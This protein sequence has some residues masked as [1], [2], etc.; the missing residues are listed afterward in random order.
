MERVF[1]IS[2]IYPPCDKTG[3][4]R[5]LAI[6]KYFHLNGYYPVILTRNWDYP[7]KEDLDYM[8]STGDHIVEKNYDGHQEV[9]LPYEGNFRT[10][11][12]IKYLNRFKLL[13]KVLF[14]IDFLLMS[15]GIYRFSEYKIFYDYLFQY[16]KTHNDVK[17]IIIIGAPFHMFHI[18]FLLKKRFNV[19][20]IADYRDD[21]TTSEIQ[22]N[23]FMSV[24]HKIIYQFECKAEKK[25]VSTASYITSV[26]DVYTKRIADYVGV[27]GETVMNGYYEEQYQD[28][29]PEA[30][31]LFNEFTIFHN[32]TLYP[33]QKVEIF[34]E[35]YKLFIDDRIRGT[36]KCKLLFI[37][38]RYWEG[39]SEKIE[40]VLKGY[41]DYF[42]LT[43]RIPKQELIDIMM[44]S[45]VNLMISHGK[46][47]RGIASS[48]IFDY[49]MSRKP[50]IC[51]PSDGDIVE[52]LLTRSG[53]GVFCETPQEVYQELCK[54]SEK[55]MQ[56]EPYDSPFNEEEVV[57]FSR[58]VQTKR[59]AMLLD[60]M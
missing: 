37:G 36:N 42:E 27:A 6:S 18:G 4:D 52:E 17:K 25:W 38:I 29:K 11:F 28:S 60:K 26:S 20:W 50:V 24:F 55:Y 41:E 48:K 57:Q 19:E 35:G 53:Q 58:R 22:S 21:W 33:T 12:K 51:S 3:A 45:H 13:S 32:G 8:R 16:F 23:K 49:M 7:L 39:I 2:Y 54:L 47:I 14:F 43:Y 1:V 59:F 34:L 56:K 40:S 9:Y 15:I 10:R 5:A 31:T 46:H 30:Y 44:R